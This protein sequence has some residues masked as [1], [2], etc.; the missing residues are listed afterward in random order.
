MIKAKNVSFSY[1]SDTPVL[2]DLTFEVTPGSL[3]ALFGPNGSGK[4]TLFKCCMNLLKITGGTIE[5]DGHDISDMPFSKTS[6]LISYVA[7]E[8]KAPFNFS[9]W[10][11]V[12]MG[13]NPH[14][15]DVFRVCHSDKHAA[16]KAIEDV[17][18][19]HLVKRNFNELSGGERQMV[20]LARAL[21]QNAKVMFLDEPTSALDFG[22][23][24][25]IWELTKT[26]SQTGVSVIACTHNPNHVLWYA[27]DV[28]LLNKGTICAHGSTDEVFTQEILDTIYP[29]HGKI[30][31]VGSAKMILPKNIG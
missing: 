17:G 26:I 23:Q 19:T 30:K 31:T 11:M 25:K 3:C 21:A 24:V 20:L 9:V 16:I 22:N 29:G 27:N 18:I 4:T 8:Y 14:M 12:L 2:K 6:R 10:E 13:R 28:I 7:Q 1:V 5:I 15:G